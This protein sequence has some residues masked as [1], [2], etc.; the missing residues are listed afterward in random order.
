MA[1]KPVSTGVRV[2]RKDNQPD[3]LLH[4]LKEPSGASVA[5]PEPRDAFDI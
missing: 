2:C 4:P 3:R 1:Y 5:L